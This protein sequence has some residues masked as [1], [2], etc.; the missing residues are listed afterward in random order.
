MIKQIGTGMDIEKDG[1]G[2][3]Q[4]QSNQAGVFRRMT[5]SGK[6]LLSNLDITAIPQHLERT[7][8]YITHYEAVRTT[9]KFCVEEKLDKAIVQTMGEEYFKFSTTGWV[10]SRQTKYKSSQVLVEGY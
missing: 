1:G 8:H 9:T 10:Q 7:A 3:L 4:A 2:A 6:H 5:K